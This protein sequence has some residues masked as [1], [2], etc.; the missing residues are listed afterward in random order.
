M[1]GFGNSLLRAVQQRGDI[2]PAGGNVSTGQSVQILPF[3]GVSA[4]RNQV[5]F[6]ESGLF[7][8]PFCESLNWNEVFEQATWLGST[9]AM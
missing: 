7:F 1:D 3:C 8:I 5:N 9:Q 4:V 6:H 2:C